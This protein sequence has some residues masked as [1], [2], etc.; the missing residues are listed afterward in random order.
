MQQW[1]S[2]RVP[3][4]SPRGLYVRGSPTFNPVE[5]LS[6]YP[7][8][9][10]LCSLICIL[11]F[12]TIYTL[13][14]MASLLRLLMIEDIDAE[15]QQILRELRNGGYYVDYERVETC[16]AMETALLHKV[17]DVILCDEDLLLFN[18][19]EAL[20]I[21]Q[22]SGH[23]LPFFLRAGISGKDTLVTIIHSVAR[24][25]VVKESLVPLLSGLAQELQDVAERR[26]QKYPA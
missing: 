3:G 21:L 13:Y 5:F 8:Q 4:R 9:I 18:P 17:W 6:L 12:C 15:A 23:R 19:I 11:P 1:R 2:I 14:T 26:S 22:E 20:A 16:A 24:D 10:G 25:F 7:L